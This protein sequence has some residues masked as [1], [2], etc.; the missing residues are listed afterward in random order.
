MAAKKQK[1]VRVIAAELGMSLG[2]I[3]EAKKAGIDAHDIAGLRKFKKG[4]RPRVDSRSKLSAAP[5]KPPEPSNQMTL[6]DIEKA[7]K[8]KGI[9][10]EDA[11]TLKRQL[12]GLKMA[13]AVRKEM[14]QLLSR[15]E[16][17]QRDIKIGSAVAAAMR[18]LETEIPQL[19][20]GLPLARSRPIVKEKVRGIQAMLSDGLSDFWKE[21]PEQ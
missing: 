8:A 1:T 6:D 14:N 17:D 5:A 11:T 4:I 7:L 16:V 15:A 12:E 21:H 3:N 13:T 20:L 9:S 10:I 2:Q 19:C 18:A